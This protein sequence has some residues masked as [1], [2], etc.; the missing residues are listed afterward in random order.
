MEE[1]IFYGRIP[2]RRRQEKRDVELLPREG[3]MIMFKIEWIKNL[4]RGF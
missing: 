4:D 2:F 3:K 1:R